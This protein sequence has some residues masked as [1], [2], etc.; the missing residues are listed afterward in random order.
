MAFEQNQL[1]DSRTA[2]LLSRY[3]ELMTL[4][5]LAEVLKYPSRQALLDAHRRELLPV[6]LVKMPKR[7]ALFAPTCAVAE[8]LNGLPSSSYFAK[9]SN[10]EATMT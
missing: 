4:D 6:T 9:S 2:R 8:F 1:E 7:R 5:E 3:G 10:G